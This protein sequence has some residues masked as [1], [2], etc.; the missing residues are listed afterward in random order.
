MSLHALSSSHCDMTVWVYR[1]NR[2]RCQMVVTWICHMLSQKLLHSAESLVTNFQLKS[3]KSGEILFKNVLFLRRLKETYK[4]I[5]C[6]H[7][8]TCTRSQ[9]AWVEN[10]DLD[11]HTLRP[12]T[13]FQSTFWATQLQ[14]TSFFVWHTVLDDLFQIVACFIQ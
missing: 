14:L 11:Q 9:S 12:T 8:S 2:Q 4:V 1:A 5:Q 3:A 7:F 10:A 13:F 6:I